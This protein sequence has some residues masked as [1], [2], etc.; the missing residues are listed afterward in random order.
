MKSTAFDAVQSKVFDEVGFGGFFESLGLGMDSFHKDY[1]KDGYTSMTLQSNVKYIREIRQDSPFEVR[2]QMLNYDHRFL[3]YWME[4]WNTG[5]EEYLV[6]SCERISICA[7]LKTRGSSGWP[8]PIVER[9]GLEWERYSP[10]PFPK[11][12]GEGG[13]I[14]IRS[15]GM[16]AKM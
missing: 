7:N 10:L 15:G 4:L 3:H 6:S 12:A 14:G 8:E 2:C 9:L 16:R 11:G 1:S 5:D 13:A